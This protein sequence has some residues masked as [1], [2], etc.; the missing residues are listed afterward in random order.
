MNNCIF[1]L[2]L[3]VEAGEDDYTIACLLMVYVAITIPRLAR[4]DGSSFKASFEGHFFYNYSSRII[5][6]HLI[7][8]KQ[9][10]LLVLSF[11]TALI[12]FFTGYLKARSPNSVLF[13][14]LVHTSF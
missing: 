1:N 14:L 6:L 3:F 7:M 8:F 12:V 2:S 13:F 10:L 5:F 11:T 4:N 9:H